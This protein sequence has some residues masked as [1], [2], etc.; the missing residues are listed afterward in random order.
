V[1]VTGSLKDP[2]FSLLP[3]V[4]KALGNLIARAVT[5]PFALLGNALDGVLDVRTHDISFVPG[6]DTLSDAAAGPLAVL[7]QALKDRPGAGVEISTWVDPIGE[8]AAATAVLLAA[9][10]VSAGRDGPIPVNDRSASTAERASL[11]LGPSWVLDL[12]R[13]RA[14]ALRLALEAQGVSPSQIVLKTDVTASQPA[15]AVPTGPDGAVPGARL[16]LVAR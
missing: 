5:A 8:R 10:P 6:T 1:P 16:Q 12:A 7:G 14:V 3:V 15:P 11:S 9:A 13:R 4:F 2:E